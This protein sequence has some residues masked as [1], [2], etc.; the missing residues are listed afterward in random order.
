V[1]IL[2]PYIGKYPV[3]T[4]EQYCLGF[5]TS[6]IYSCNTFLLNPF[7]FHNRFIHIGQTGNYKTAIFYRFF[8]RI[9]R[10]NI[11]PCS[12][13]H[14]FGKSMFCL[15]S[16]INL[17]F[18]KTRQSELQAEKLCSHIDTCSYESDFFG[19]RIGN[20]FCYNT[21]NSAGSCGAYYLCIHYAERGFRN[22]I[23]EYCK[24]C[25]SRKSY[26]HIGRHGS[27]DFTGINLFF[28]EVHTGRKKIYKARSMFMIFLFNFQ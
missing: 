12:F 16:G 7:C 15:S 10:H 4:F 19:F 21:C 20:F 5:I 13:A 9:Y 2:F 28:S 6:Y 17:Y 14:F 25:G 8:C 24:T 26:F 27:E 3:H 18:F 11:E 23:K 1:F 22:R